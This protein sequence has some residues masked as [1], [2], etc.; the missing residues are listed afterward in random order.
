M[1]TTALRQQHPFANRMLGNM[2][3]LTHSCS[4]TARRTQLGKLPF[5]VGLRLANDQA[6]V[7]G[8][9]AQA[10]VE[11]LAVLVAPRCADLGPVGIVAF[12]DHVDRVRSLA[13]LVRLHRTISRLL[14]QLR[15]SRPDGSAK[16]PEVISSGARR[17][18]PR[19]PLGYGW[20]PCAGAP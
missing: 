3:A 18:R 12:F 6:A 7:H 10:D 14:L 16:G 4:R 11:A 17:L 20:M 15:Q 9:A 5:R 1:R 13:L 8:Q 19:D 2:G